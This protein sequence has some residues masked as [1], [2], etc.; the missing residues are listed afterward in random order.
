[1]ALAGVVDMVTNEAE[2][3]SGA[4]SSVAPRAP[5]RWTQN[6]RRKCPTMAAGSA[7]DC[8][9]STSGQCACPLLS[10]RREAP[11]GPG[12]PLRHRARKSAVALTPTVEAPRREDAVRLDVVVGQQLKQRPTRAAGT[13][14]DGLGGEQR[15]RWMRT[16]K[17][18]SA[19]RSLRARAGCEGE[20]CRSGTASPG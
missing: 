16:R 7:H 1:M 11:L 17:K 20:R 9:Q 19:S 12:R 6:G 5:V 3:R 18:P 4:C 15:R 14:F 10:R 13:G 8:P 2:E